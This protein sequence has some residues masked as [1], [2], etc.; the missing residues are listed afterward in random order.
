MSDQY[1]CIYKQKIPVL[2]CLRGGQQSQRIKDPDPVSN[3]VTPCRSYVGPLFCSWALLGCILRVLLRLLSVLGVSDA[4]W[5]APGSTLEGFWGRRAWFWRS[6][7]TILAR[8]CTH[9]RQ[10]CENAPTLKKLWQ[11]QQK[12]RFGA[13]RFFHVQPRHR[14]K[15]R[16]KCYQ[17]IVA[18]RG[19]KSTNEN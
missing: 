18:K 16:S 7:M 8:F 6:K 11:G 3:F 15:K 19:R 2:T 10:R 13:T 12:S 1:V 4:S 9:T 5:V 14:A 17:K